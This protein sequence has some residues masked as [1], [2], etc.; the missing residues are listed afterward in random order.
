[1]GVHARPA[2]QLEGQERLEG[3]SSAYRLP[4]WTAVHRVDLP[5]FRMRWLARYRS[6]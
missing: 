1:M 2:L 4:A 5:P 3:S 6:A